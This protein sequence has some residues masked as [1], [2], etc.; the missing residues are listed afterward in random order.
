MK[1]TNAGRLFVVLLAVLAVEAGLAMWRGQLLVG[2]HEGDMLHL[3]EIV[4][5]MADGEWPHLDFMT[6]IGFMAFA[7][8]ALFVKLGAGVGSSILY[9]QALMGLLLLPL[10]W[11]AGL[12][13]LTGYWPYLFGALVIVL[14]TALV[15]GEAERSVSISMHYNRWAWAAAFIAILIATLPPVDGHK[16]QTADGIVVGL[17]LA[18]LA[19]CKV[20][21]FAAFVIPVAVGLL[22]HKQHRAFM[23]ALATGL[24]IVAVVTAF[25]GLDF[26]AAYMRDLL[27]V[28]AS[29][30]RA[31]PGAPFAAV[32]AAPAYLGGSIVLLFS[33]I[34]LRQ[35]KKMTEGLVLLLL[36]PGFFYVTFQNFGNDPQWLLLL[37]ILLFAARPEGGITNGAG[38][39]M[40]TAVGLS[41]AA[42]FAM[43]VPSAIN[44]AYSPIR[45]LGQD[46][47]QHVPLLP[48]ATLHADLQT[49]TVRALRADK[50]VPMEVPG[51]GLD[52]WAERA[53]RGS[54]D[55]L[56]GEELP[57]CEVMLG[58]SALFDSMATSLEESGHAGE[59]IFIADLFSSI[60]LFGDFER[61]ENGAPW[62]YGGLPG[63]DTADYILVPQCSI[64]PKVR[65]LVLERIGQ[66]GDTLIEVSRT[67]LY[68]LLEKG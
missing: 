18:F 55:V 22:A 37:G 11:R 44:L 15:H 60:W 36:T 63:Y 50:R 57:R 47:A 54:A 28:S 14:V 7:P 34:L 4:F 30:V 16:N 27:R 17:A 67:P 43:I 19:L 41:G 9:A 40:R 12:S 5:R 29:E 45:H 33:V 66:R 59:R 32:I 65:G 24:T 68:I 10:A 38:W 8:I 3:L 62:Y 39:D 21:Y 64:H 51:S 20:T 1:K 58:L 49:G 23:F 26:W 46:A 56:N 53:E 2:K 13:R 25:A 31:N 61:L 6:P 52:V 48:R 42:A 35:A